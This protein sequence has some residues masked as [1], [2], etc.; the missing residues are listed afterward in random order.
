M[1]AEQRLLRDAASTLLSA[2]SR[3]A[4][5]DRHAARFPDGNFAPDRERARRAA[6]RDLCR[7]PARAQAYLAAHPSGTS[8]DLVRSTCASSTAD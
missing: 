7:E 3:L 2:E 1:E 4:A 6:V 5:I 8:S